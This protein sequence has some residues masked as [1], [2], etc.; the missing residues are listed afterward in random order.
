MSEQLPKNSS[1]V[2][3]LLQTH[4]SQ[5][6]KLALAILH[7]PSSEPVWLANTTTSVRWSK[8]TKLYFNGSLILS[9]PHTGGNT[10]SVFWQSF[11]FPSDT[12]FENQNFTISMSLVSSNGIFSMRLGDDYLGA[13]EAKAEIVEGEGPIYAQLSTNGFLGM[14]QNLKPPVDVLPF[15]SFQRPLPG[16]R[17]LKLESDGNLRGYYWNGSSWITDFE[18]ISDKCE[19]PSSCGSYSLCRSGNGGCSCLDDRTQYRSGQCFPL[20]SGDFCSKSEVIGNGFWILR[21]KGVDLPYKELMEFQKMESLE[22]CESSCERNCS[23]WGAVFNNATGYCYKVDYPINTLVGVGDES[24]LGFFKV[25][26]EEKKRVV[27]VAVGVGLVVGAVLEGHCEAFQRQY[28]SW[29]N[30][31]NVGPIEADSWQLRPNVSTS[32]LGWGWGPPPIYNPTGL[33]KNG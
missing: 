3:Q 19:L 23:C 27:S 30:L 18:A 13:M 15:D 10:R 17:R 8:P 24:K 7:V 16:I 1:E 33:A 14:Y 6:S 25:R 12:L 29:L 28:N 5:R 22:E 2:S 9:D 32:F 20:K 21:R 31:T 11:D 4:P 26:N